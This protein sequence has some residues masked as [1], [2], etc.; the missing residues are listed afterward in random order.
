MTL[1]EIRRRLS[2]LAIWY[3]KKVEIWVAAVWL[4]VVQIS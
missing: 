2:D 4:A 3:R 1:P